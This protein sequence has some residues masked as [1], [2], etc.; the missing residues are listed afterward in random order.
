MFLLVFVHNVFGFFAF[1][2]S[3]ASRRFGRPPR[4]L[5]NAPRHPQD[6]PTTAQEGSKTSPARPQEAPGRRLHQ[7]KRLQH[8]AGK[9]KM[10]PGLSNGALLST[11]WLPDGSRSHVASPTALPQTASRGRRGRGRGRGF[12]VRGST[13][14]GKGEEEED[15]SGFVFSE[16]WRGSAGTRLE[17]FLA[18]SFCSDIS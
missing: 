4:L 5:K 9:P 18:G 2:G 3:N 8:S 17:Q 15:L 7:Q 1:H 14:R 16:F 10:A 12:E 6:R 13:R 11:I